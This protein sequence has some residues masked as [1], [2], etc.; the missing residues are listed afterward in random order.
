M[1]K[2]LSWNS[3]AGGVRSLI[4]K[5]TGH[6]LARAS[7]GSL[8]QYQYQT[9][10]EDD[11]WVFMNA[12]LKV[13]REVAFGKANLTANAP[14]IV[15]GYWVGKLTK[16]YRSKP[17]LQHDGPT[18]GST[19][20]GGVDSFLQLIE[21]PE[22]LHHDSGAPSAVWA[23]FDLSRTEPRINV[24]LSLFNKTRTRLP[25]AHWMD[26]ELAVPAGS[27][28][29]TPAD[30]SGCDSWVVSKLNSTFC[31]TDV[32]L[33]G[34]THV[35]A[36]SDVDSA[37]KWETGGVAVGVRSLDA[38]VVALEYKSALPE[39]VNRTVDDTG[40]QAAS[41]YVNLINNFWTTNYPN[42]YPFSVG[43]GDE[44]AVFRFELAVT[45]P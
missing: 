8:M 22:K 26:F 29:S 34:A 17:Q 28:G 27:T 31:A 24:T 44:D 25:E 36:V 39:H 6:N 41:A 42:W 14:G 35:H 37:L 45:V 19:E 32:S 40:V 23:R 7:G 1:W 2:E 20:G 9:L 13:Q 12:T 18:D 5:S 33:F 11:F 10:D 4:E 15:S 43:E 38:A 30:A 21:M 3:T 16:M